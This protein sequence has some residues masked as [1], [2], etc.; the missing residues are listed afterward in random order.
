MGN[1]CCAARG[2]PSNLILSGL[3]QTN[4]KLNHT[5]ILFHRNFKILLFLFCFSESYLTSGQRYQSNIFLSFDTMHQFWD[6]QSLLYSTKQGDR[7]TLSI[8]IR[9]EQGQN[10]PKTI[11]CYYP[12]KVHSRSLYFLI[13]ICVFLPVAVNPCQDSKTLSKA[14]QQLG[15]TNVAAS[16]AKS[17]TEFKSDI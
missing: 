11:S 17:D 8:Q 15:Y 13:C 12:F 16:V 6:R 10:R 4:I 5:A 2:F 14:P 1:E 9:K 3:R 7:G